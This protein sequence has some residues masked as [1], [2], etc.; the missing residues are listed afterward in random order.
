MIAVF[1]SEN[2][3]VKLGDFGLSKI[4]A[5]HDFASTYVGTPF[6]M[7]PE[8][9]AA[10]RY[11][12]HSD[13]WSLG[14]IIYELASRCVPFDAR[15][16][17]ELQTKIKAGRIKPLPEMYSRELWDVIGWCLKVDPRQR[18]D[19][20]QLLN[21]AQIKAARSKL[22][23]S[24]A[25]ERMQHERE[26]LRVQ[27][28]IA[29][30]QIQQLQVEVKRLTD[31]GKKTEMELHAKATL[32]IDQQVSV[33]KQHFE[34]EKNAYR[35]ELQRMFDQAVDQKVQEHW[36]SLPQS[37]GLN[38]SSEAAVH[39]RSSTPPPGKANASFATTAT[40][41]VESDGSSVVQDQDHSA[42]DTDLSSLSIGDGDDV[43]P[44][45]QRI[46][47]LKKLGGRQPFGRAKTLAN[48]SFDMGNTQSPMD[49]HMAD[50]S[51]RH[52]AAP[53][54][55]KGLSLSPRHNAGRD[56]LSGGLGLK[57]NM[58]TMAA[59]QKLRPQ[60]GVEHGWSSNSFADDDLL[61][62]E[63]ADCLENS[64][65]R[66]SSGL[67]NN[68]T[69]ISGNP[70]NVLAAPAQPQLPPKRIARPSLVRQ[71]TMPTQMQPAIHQRQNSNLFNPTRKASP[72][73]ENRPPS[74]SNVPVLT[75]S[76]KRVNQQTKDAKALTPSRKAPPPPSSNNLVKPAYANN[77]PGKVKGRTLIELQQ[78]R[79]LPH[80]AS[81]PDMLDGTMLLA[82]GAKLLASPAKWD[83][84][85]MGDEMPSPFL[86]RK[87]RVGLA[88]R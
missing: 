75:T 2:N 27:L 68:G 25:V 16:H 82:T 73:K 12:H 50:P 5:S 45:A 10:E 54:S 20:A 43:S 17:F 59:D 87:G 38:Q 15:S 21:V 18:P 32:A 80:S 63:E 88:A 72:E 31:A 76:P 23:Q 85:E 83:P 8:I 55:I 79:Q 24:Q 40:T 39:V 30:K 62:D 81:E 41:T 7:S 67:S 51:P 65:S 61:D 11:S 56:R 34:K 70:F 69:A 60:I 77:T 46:K 19:T 28:D 42:L 86:A 9:C 71:Q 78:A 13:V 49:V 57:R 29:Q 4:I 52:Q 64:P 35:S 6:Y 74:R 36:T 33:A 84:M 37:H 58:F 1:L 26:E 66:P 47:P 48:C 14:C 44:L 22:Q 53:M 3:A